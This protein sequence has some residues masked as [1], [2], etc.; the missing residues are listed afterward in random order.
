M[1]R[2]AA[3]YADRWNSYGTS[4][5][6]RERNARLDDACVEIGRDPDE[7]ELVMGAPV[8]VAKSDADA[9][10][11]LSRIPPERRPYVAVGPPAK[12]A[13]A[14]RPYLDAGFVGFTFGNTTYRTPDQIA[15]VGEVLSLIN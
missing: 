2:I 3:R 7:I 12:A 5:Q 8:I 9:E 1:L 15:A 10:E 14:L 11:Q 13:E 6:I 4:D